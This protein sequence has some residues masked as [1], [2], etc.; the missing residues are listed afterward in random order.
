[1][2]LLRPSPAI[3][4][5]VSRLF[6]SR[7]MTKILLNGL[8]VQ[9][10]SWCVLQ[11]LLKHWLQNR[12]Q[13]LLDES[14]HFGVTTRCEEFVSA[15]NPS[16]IEGVA[17]KDIHI[18]LFTLPSVHIFLPKFAL[19][20]PEPDSSRNR[21]LNHTRTRRMQRRTYHATC[22]ICG[23]TATA[24]R[25]RRWLQGKRSIREVAAAATA[26]PTRK[27]WVWMGNR[28]GKWD[29]EL[30][31]MEKEYDGDHDGDHFH[32]RLQNFLSEK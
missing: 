31:S 29:V 23:G 28:R 27:R 15:P 21:N 24:P 30:R 6:M 22:F 12:I 9:F 11:V 26:V 2:V 5:S 25:M 16:F 1:M 32:L 10:P 19:N 8:E 18:D 4:I 14:D 7:K 20:H 3:S 17:T 13:S